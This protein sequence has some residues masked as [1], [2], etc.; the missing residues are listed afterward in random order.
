MHILMLTNRIPYP[1]KDGGSLA[2]HYFIEG[3]LEAGVRL[4]L[5]AMNTTKHYTDQQSLPKVYKEL[6]H[7]KT[8]DIDNSINVWDAFVNLF[9]TNKSYNI[10]RFVSKDYE[11]QLITLL[12][13][14]Q[15]DFI[16]LES[17][18]LAPYL[19]IIRK[20]S[21]A[22]IVLR[23]HNIEYKIWEK[24]FLQEKNIFKKQYLQ[25]L[26]KR[27]KEYELAHI[28]AFDIILPISNLDKAF[29]VA[30]NCTSP[31]YTQTFGIKIKDNEG[32]HTP[33]VKQP[34][35]LYHLGAMDWRPNLESVK[36]LVYEVMPEIFKTHPEA[37][38]YL[39][40]RN[41]P[42]SL[43]QSD[44]PN[45][46]VIGEV[47][48]AYSFEQDKHVLLVPLLSGGGV[49]IKIFQGMAIGKAVVTTPIGV[50]GIEVA[51]KEH[52]LVADNK[53]EFVKYVRFLIDRPDE[54]ERLG[55]NAQTTIRG[56]Y[57]RTQQIA[58]LLDFLKTQ[59][60]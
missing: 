52:L 44:F 20:Y 11:T 5:L 27:L 59:L 37:T 46:K 16:Q 38:L 14:D 40:G 58:S 26:T 32:V 15:Y 9:Q 39:A 35:K 36:W 21:K 19:P 29:Y 3:Y 57:N 56:Q 43:L 33:E 8:V 42:P 49:R 22:K 55:K 50:E 25:L 1:L 60:N 47:E 17:L 18:F 10:E 53:E 45:I 7:F 24:L 6:T 30:N 28:N 2:M 34:I 41:M 4:S 23:S 48:D 51:H 12:T 31:L 54:I 13:Q